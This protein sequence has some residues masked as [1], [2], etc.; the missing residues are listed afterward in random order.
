VFAHGPAFTTT[1]WVCSWVHGNTTNMRA[2]P[3]MAVTTSF[4]QANVL[5]IRVTDLA[6]GGAAFNMNAT[7][8]TT[9]KC[10]QGI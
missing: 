1:M 8:L 6:N 7:K 3:F 5:M 4:A 2:L 9:W 10:K